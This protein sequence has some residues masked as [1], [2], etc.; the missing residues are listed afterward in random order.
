MDSDYLELNSNRLT[1]NNVYDYKVTMNTIH[2][3]TLNKDDKI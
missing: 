3:Y 2:T 1:E